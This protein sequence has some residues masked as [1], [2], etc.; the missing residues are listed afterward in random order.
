[1]RILVTA[2]R[3]ITS[4]DRPYLED[5]L[6]EVAGDAPGP[7]T[8]V[9]G[10][11]RGGDTVFGKIAA[12]WGWTVEEHPADWDGPCRPG[13]DKPEGHGPRQPKS[14]GSGTYCPGAGKYRNSDM[15]A[16]GA[17]RGVAAL[18]QGARNAGTKDC[19]LKMRVAG[20]EVYRVMV[21]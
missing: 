17:D 1:V 2:S 11:A 6:R 20:I 10:K 5:G 13:C 9:H 21:P 12:D 4:E 16:L 14:Y 19:A 3:L 7:H 15:V 18:K 8:L